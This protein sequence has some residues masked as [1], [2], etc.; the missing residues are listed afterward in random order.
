LRIRLAI[1]LLALLIC[2]CVSRSKGTM[3][4][5]PPTATT[6][7]RPTTHPILYHRT[8]GI[9][10]TDDRVVIWPDGLVQVTGKVLA[11]GTT[12]VPPERLAKLIGMLRGWD[13]LRDE[14]PADVADAYSIAISYGDKTVTAFDLAPDLPE[15]F[16][17]VYSEIEAIAADVVNAAQKSEAA[18]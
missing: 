10:G 11:P 16:R 8:G 1:P 12:R 4:A 13:H 5:S 7:A 2:G 18:P 9:A 6:H 15:Q 17:K 3:V 14:Y